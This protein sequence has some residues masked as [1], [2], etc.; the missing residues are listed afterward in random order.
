MTSIPSHNVLNVQLIT[1]LIN[2]TLCYKFLLECDSVSATL[3]I[4]VSESHTIQLFAL[5]PNSYPFCDG[6]SEDWKGVGSRGMAPPS[7]PVNLGYNSGSIRIYKQQMG[8]SDW[9]ISDE[10]IVSRNKQLAMGWPF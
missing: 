8:S 5:S 3:E 2:N 10:A 4:T 6:K 7:L 1:V 9:L